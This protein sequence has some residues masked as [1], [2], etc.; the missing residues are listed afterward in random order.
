[1]PKGS[2]TRAADSAEVQQPAAKRA[3]VASTR[4]IGQNP[5]VTGAVA[6]N[7]VQPTTAPTASTRGRGNRRRGRGGATNLIMTQTHQAESTV[8]DTSG[9][10]TTTQRN[11]E[12][13]TSTETITPQHLSTSTQTEVRVMDGG[14]I[15]DDEILA[16]GNINGNS[17]ENANSSASSENVL[18]NRIAN[19]FESSLNCVRNSSNVENS[20]AISRLSLF[21]KELPSFSGEPREWMYFKQVYDDSTVEGSYSDSENFARLF[22]AL[23]GEARK[24]V[25]SLLATG[26]NANSIVKTLELRFGNKNVIARDLVDELK[27]CLT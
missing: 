20:R 6:D 11:T 27:P 12:D 4:R 24:V 17:S 26:R 19:A 1:M 5:T 16:S 23:K 2:R 13:D 14:V 21:N 8:V 9:D 22:V 10:T 3:R 18:L 25:S 15:D 7:P